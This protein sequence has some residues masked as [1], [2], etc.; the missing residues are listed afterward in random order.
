[1]QL[2]VDEEPT[3]DTILLFKNLGDIINIF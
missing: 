3:D 1:M 2:D